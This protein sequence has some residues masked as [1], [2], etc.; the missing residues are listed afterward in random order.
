MIVQR[1]RRAAIAGGD[2]P[3]HAEMQQQQPVA[4][5]LDQDVLA[6]PAEYPDLGAAEP[7]GKFRWKR[8]PQVGPAQLGA[9]DPPAGHL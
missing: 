5:E 1:R 8:A 6:A 2:P 9:H 4:A 3:R 7:L